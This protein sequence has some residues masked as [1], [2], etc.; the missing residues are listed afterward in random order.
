MSIPQAI[1]AIPA[2]VTTQDRMTAIARSLR[3]FQRRLAMPARCGLARA[4][5]LLPI[6]PS[7]FEAYRSYEEALAAV[8]AR[9][10]I[11]Y[12]HQDI[13]DISFEVMCRVQPWDYPVLFWLERLLPQV[14][15]VVDA[16][17]HMG[18]KFRAFGKFLPLDDTI[19][20][21]VYDLP[22]IVR[23]GRVLAERDGLK[24]L[25]FSETP[26]GCPPSEL[27]LA[28]GLLQYLDI[29]FSQFVARLQQ[30]P[31]HLVLNK[32]ALREGP[33][34]VT[35]ENIGAAKVPYQ[36]RNREGFMIELAA[37]GYEVVDEWTNTALSH[38]IVTRPDL[39]ES[40]N[41]GFYLRMGD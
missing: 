18:T 17:G 37:L 13:A 6:R 34:I 4:R 25:R 12:D 39:G 30:K 16:G 1:S 5:Y 29:P 2:A 31:K 19:E 23:A 7:F 33:T 15:R 14:S 41:T 3:N 10:L 27:L 40:S 22:S 9:S 20:W 24:T 21:V 35:L 32:V 8:P 26:E 38:R 36:V 28:S 11:G